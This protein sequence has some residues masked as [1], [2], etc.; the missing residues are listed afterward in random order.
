M[1]AAA[2][3]A[4]LVLYFN[5]LC[6]RMDDRSS[7]LLAIADR[8]GPSNPMATSH[9]QR[10]ARHLRLRAARLVELTFA[11]FRNKFIACNDFNIT[12]IKYMIEITANTQI[13]LQISRVSGAI[14]RAKGLGVYSC[15]T[16]LTNLDKRSKE[17]RLM[18]KVRK[19][20]TYHLGGSP[21]PIQRVLIERAAI[22]SLRVAM[23]DTKI[24]NGEMLTQMYNVQYLAWSNGLVRTLDKLG[25]TP[26]AGPQPSLGDV[27]ADIVARRAPL[28]D[29]DQETAA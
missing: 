3:P 20:L 12:Y 22:L 25:L 11:I 8:A 29:D 18:R 17:C 9:I 28:E 15:L 21:S 24:V 5:M 1:Q 26:A 19:D 7:V 6:S 16:T 23:L 2:L 4:Y 13:K 14:A 27:L 10:W